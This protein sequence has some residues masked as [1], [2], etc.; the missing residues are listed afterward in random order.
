MARITRRREMEGALARWR[1]SGLSAA[2]FCRREGLAPQ[3][4][5]YW[6]RALAR[7]TEAVVCRRGAVR[8]VGLVPV[9]LVGSAEGVVTAGGLEIVLASGDRLL[10]REGVSRELLRNALMVLRERC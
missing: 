10:V 1:R 3:V 2:A 4:L 6:K 9:R 8:P 5:S 7:P